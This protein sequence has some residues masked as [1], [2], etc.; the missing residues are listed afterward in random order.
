[1]VALAQSERF[2]PG[3]RIISNRTSPIYQSNLTHT[4]HIKV[5]P[6]SFHTLVFYAFIVQLHRQVDSASQ[7]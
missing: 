2:L 7:F 4:I 6:D 5:T 1:M 3:N